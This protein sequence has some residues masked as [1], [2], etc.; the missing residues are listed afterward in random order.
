[1]E[2]SVKPIHG[3]Y[4]V[5]SSSNGA[6]SLFTPAEY[7]AFRSILDTPAAEHGRILKELLESY[8]CN[9]E[10]TEGFIG[11]FL[12]KIRQQGWLRESFGESD[13]EMLGMVYL[14]VTTGCN[15]SCIYCYVGDDRRNP[16]QR[17]RLPDA[18]SIL[19]KIKDFNPS[20]RIAVTGGEPF[21]HP[22]IFQILDTLEEFGL[23]FTIG[24]NAVLV[25]EGCA[26][27]LGEYRNLIYVQASIDGMSCEVHSLTRGPTWNQTMQGILNLAKFNLPFALAPTLHQGNLHEMPAMARFAYSHGGFFAPNHLRKFPQAHRVDSIQL[28]PASLRQCILETFG[29][30]A[31][32]CQ[33]RSLPAGLKEENSSEIVERR[34]RYVCGN[35]GYTID[36]GWNGDVYPCHLLKD[37]DFILGNILREE[38]P[39]I[40]ERGKGGKS[41]VRSYEIEKCRECPFVGTCGGGC[42][43]SAY[44]TRGT[45]SAEDEF[46]DILYQFE[47]DKLF[48]SKG[49]PSPF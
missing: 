27:K 9:Q 40:M 5:S 25:D 47:V 41:R 10:Q 2:F 17:M 44:Y 7:L 29:G 19:Q 46:C 24:T 39:L 1:M 33:C 22:D 42:R 20:A 35:A 49:L 48:D 43:A 21:T 30:T 32:E 4:L 12:R 18:V 13:P 37:A 26:G 15:L 3:H 11:I 8:G 36:V 16:D 14:T 38:I 34:C 6:V 28:R 23:K 45:F 31:G